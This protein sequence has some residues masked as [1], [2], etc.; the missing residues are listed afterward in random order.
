MKVSR[1]LTMR[2]WLTAL[3]ALAL[4][5]LA[6]VPSA[7]AA[8]PMT[9][10]FASDTSWMAD[11]ADA[12]VGPSLTLPAPAQLVCLNASAPTGCPVGATLYGWPGGGWTADLS[13]VPGAWWIWAP[14]ID[15]STPPA[16]LDAYTFTKTI[17]VPGTPT[18]GSIAFGAD[19]NVEVFVNGTSAGTHGSPD[20]LKTVDIGSLLVE[21]DN[22]IEVHAAN[23]LIC[24]SDCPYQRNPAGVVFGGSITYEPAPSPSP[25]PSVAP[26]VEPSPSGGV[27]ELTPPP[28]ETIGEG[29]GESHSPLL[30]ALLVLVATG[31][32]VSTARWGAIRRR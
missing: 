12:G 2:R 26:S 8:G 1:P 22:T 19:D 9:I 17:S 6:M 25:D 5:S 11:D 29:P 24:G 18:A 28:T 20:S 4:L 7:L 30:P 15:G 13:G 10:T 3:A 21:G 32:I 31:L 16:D 23:A 27:G 14:G